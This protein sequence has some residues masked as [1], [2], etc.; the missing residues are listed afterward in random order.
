MTHDTSN[1]S[2]RFRAVFR[3]WPSAVA[4]LAVRD[5]QH[6]YA[7]TITSLTPVSADPPTVLASLGGSAQVVPFLRPGTRYAVSLLARDQARTAQVYSD[8]FPVGPSPFPDSGDP[9][10]PDSQGWLVL[11][12]ERLVDAPGGARLVLGTVLEGNVDPG[13]PPLLY[14]RRRYFGLDD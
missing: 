12:A 6:V 4:V 1:A 11:E 3:E 2:E 8:S 9:V 13:R 14:R 5:G 7:T 10:I